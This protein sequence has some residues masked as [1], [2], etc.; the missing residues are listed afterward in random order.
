MHLVIT[1]QLK[2]T[3]VTSCFGTSQHVNFLANFGTLNAKIRLII[4]G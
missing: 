3:L 2:I 4:T 1:E